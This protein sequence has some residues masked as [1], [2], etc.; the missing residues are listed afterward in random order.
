MVLTAFLTSIQCEVVHNH[1]FLVIVKVAINPKWPWMH[2]TLQAPAP[3]FWMRLTHVC[4]ILLGEQHG[5]YNMF[6]SCPRGS[7]S[8][9]TKSKVLCFSSL[10]QQFFP[11]K[12][13]WALFFSFSCGMCDS[14][15]TS[16]PSFASC[17]S[18][19]SRPPMC[20]SPG[21]TISYWHPNWTP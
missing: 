21:S 9:V 7:E 4:V 12:H 18:W 11:P 15:R 3:C 5:I 10:T 19:A 17:S 6:A 1:L 16:C 2:V 20:F 14:A 13:P 8:Q